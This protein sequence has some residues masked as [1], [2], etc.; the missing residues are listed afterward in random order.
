MLCYTVLLYCKEGI[1]DD[2]SVNY[3]KIMHTRGGRCVRFQDICYFKTLV[4]LSGFVLIKALLC[5]GLISYESHP[6]SLFLIPNFH[7]RP[8]SRGLSGCVCPFLRER[9]QE[10]EIMLSIHEVIL[11]QKHGMI[12]CFY[13]LFTIFAWSVCLWALVLLLLQTVMA[14]EINEI[15]W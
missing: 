8:S 9:E 5:V 2:S 10:K 13:L 15:F 3:Q 11:W 14:F 12:Y 1:I 4:I 7:F 6:M